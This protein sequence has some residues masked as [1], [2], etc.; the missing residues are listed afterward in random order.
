MGRVLLAGAT[1]WAGPACVPSR[2]WMLVEDG[3]VAAVGG[4]E[5]PPPADRVVDLP[6]CHLLPGFT[7]VHL[8]LSQAAWIPRGGD[9]WGWRG[10]A[11]ALRAVR[12]AGNASP[13]A[14]WLLFWNVARWSWPEGRLP[15]RGELDE[16]A[17]GR[18]VLVSSSDLHRGS[19][20]SAGL[21]AIGPAEGDLAKVF[22][23]DIARD[24][25]GRPTGE[26]WEAAY[27]V[28][29]QRALTSTAA[30]ARDAGTAAV[31]AAEAGRYLA[32]GITH[33]HD[34][35][36]A[37]DSCEPMD[38][39]RAVGPLRVSWATGAPDG[40]LSRPPGPQDAPE[41]PYGDAGRE[42]KV[43]ADGADRCA[44]TLP[45]QA[46]PGL[47]GG[48]VSESRRL[49]GLGPL[50]ESARR[51]TII[52]PWQM[53]TPYLRYTDTDLAGLMT[54]YAGA[55]IRLRIHAFGNRAGAQAARVIRR[56]GLPAGA[57]TIDHLVLL[58]AATAE[59]VA[60]SGASVS[61]QPGFLEPYGQMLR[62]VRVD[63]YAT[64]LGGRMLLDAGVP[65]AI[66]SDHPSGPLDPLHNLRASVSRQLPRG[67]T[68]QPGQAIT[69]QD[70]V[71]A[72]TVAAASSLGAPAGGLAA[73]E[74]ADF[75]VCDGDPF[76]PGTRVTQ[77][78][79]A[80]EQAWPATAAGQ[81]SG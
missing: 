12:A 77:T 20:S 5:P 79:I 3:R 81:P 73:G 40:I 53:H 46:L 26:L 45:L 22:G 17:P 38:A 7:D 70:A 16:A 28:A 32:H 37:P 57:A 6:G 52:R 51:K 29:L 14:P 48:A 27:G 59:L 42:V 8:H 71:R 65:L 10:L 30:H 56:A 60:A 21:E 2:A 13:Q 50:R 75:V 72:Y 41:G 54:A 1:V 58:D 15:T 55:E 36:L 49:R 11:E 74:P 61:Y 47:L 39:L 33:A 18:R 34:P 76:T 44:V 67:R 64:V 66:S 43:F 80:G 68:L 63:R 19:V 23:A 62:Q 24:R 25:R 9:G 4:Q 35:Y 31:Y 69:Q 78:W